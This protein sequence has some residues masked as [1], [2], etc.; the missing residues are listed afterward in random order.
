LEVQILSQIKEVEKRE[1]ILK[2]HLKKR[3]EDLNKLEAEFSQQERR[4]EEEIVTLEIQV[5]EAKR[6]K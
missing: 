3:Y 2:S 6:T 4:L 5:E 1:E